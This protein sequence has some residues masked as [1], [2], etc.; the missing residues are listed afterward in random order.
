MDF[1]TGNDPSREPDPGNSSREIGDSGPEMSGG[2]GNGDFDLGDPVQ[3]FIR[4]VQGVLL[5]PVGFF[6]ELP[7][8][9]G[10][11]PPLVFALICSVIAGVLA[12]IVNAL[13]GLTFSNQGIGTVLGALVFT[14]FVGAAIF[15]LLVFLL[16]KPSNAGFEATFRVGAYISATQLFSWL[17]GVPILGI[18]ISLAVGVYSIVLAVLGIREMHSTTTGRAVA[19]VLIPV[20]AAGI[21]GLL[22]AVVIGILIAA[23]FSQ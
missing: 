6:R 20:V 10:F 11:V 7:R 9:G 13:V 14:I 4:T 19:V 16:V 23:A 15:H 3:S 18:L 22:I 5:N 12:G 2:S 17:S 8:Q 21:I 1:S